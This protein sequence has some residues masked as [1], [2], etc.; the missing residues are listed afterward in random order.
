MTDT[1]PPRPIHIDE[2]LPLVGRT[3]DADCDPR[4]VALELVSATP[5]VNHAKLER[6][7]FILILRA[8]P[9]TVLVSGTYVFSGHGFGPDVIDIIQIAAPASGAPGNYYQAVFN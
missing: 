1:P 8:A 7:P 6:L 5:T 3:L 2:F 9:E 4:S